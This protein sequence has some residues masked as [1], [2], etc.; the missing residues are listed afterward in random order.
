MRKEKNKKTLESEHFFFKKI[1]GS[2]NKPFQ[3][4][5][6]TLQLCFSL[7]KYVVV[8]QALMATLKLHHSS[9]QKQVNKQKN[10]FINVI[11]SVLDYCDH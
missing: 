11:E 5:Y 4:N 10:T 7:K 9:T 3:T 1:E 6:E 8:G 2:K